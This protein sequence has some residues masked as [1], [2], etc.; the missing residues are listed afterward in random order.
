[1]QRAF[2][3]PRFGADFSGVRVHTGGEAAQ[4]NRAISARAF[5]HGQDIFLGEGQADLESSAGQR[6]LAHELTHVVQQGEGPIPATTERAARGILQR[7]RVPSGAGLGAALPTGANLANVRPGLARALSRA[8]GELTEEQR[9][10]VVVHPAVTTRIAPD[11]SEADVLTALSTATYIQLLSFARAIRVADPSAGLGD[12]LL[13]NVG[14]RAG[15]DD[16]RNIA[17]LVTK[18]NEVFDRIES[19]EWDADIAQVFGEDNVDEAKGK[20]D[21]ARLQMNE[22]K[23]T[24]KIVTDRS[25]YS[26]EVSLAGRTDS[27]QIALA[28]SVIDRPEK[29]ESVITLIHESMHAGNGDVKDKG[30]AGSSSFRVMAAPVKLT[31]AAHFEVVPRRILAPASRYAFAGQ[32]FV[33]AGTT[34][35]GVTAPAMTPREQAIHGASETFR[36]AW[37]TGQ[38]LHKLLVRAFKTPTEWNTHHL[39][40]ILPF[41]SKVEGLTIHMRAASINPAGAPEVRPVTLIDIAL[42]EGLIRKLH[43]GMASV[44]KDEAA[45]DALERAVF[46]ELHA[47]PDQLEAAR[48]SVE[49]E[50]KLLIKLVI[51]ERLGSITGDVSRDE[52]VVARLAQAGEA[53]SSDI[54]TRH[55]LS[56]FED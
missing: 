9:A 1:V 21:F 23:D 18:A 38:G 55:D 19:G 10:A 54:L 4:L 22:I 32:T 43:Q 5:T 44:P 16:V 29:P 28:A 46:A 37:H 24:S 49:K 48:A 13:I 17:T 40:A 30:Y 11:A 2:M 3:E 14:A 35:G 25:G 15:T 20:Y 39:S 6:L 26:E 51:R 8:W 42:S 52:R 7:R 27:T 36:A 41:W 53:G 47:A 33:P 50:Q 34:A 56:E 45:A 31:N 12:P